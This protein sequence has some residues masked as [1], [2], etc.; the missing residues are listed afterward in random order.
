M[1]GPG[2][3]AAEGSLYAA[4]S[5]RH[6]QGPFDEVFIRSYQ[7]SADYLMTAWLH[8]PFA[9][10][11]NLIVQKGYEGI[12]GKRVYGGPS[13]YYAVDYT[14]NA[15]IVDADFETTWGLANIGPHINGVD[16]ADWAH[17]GAIAQSLLTGGQW[18]LNT[19]DAD[20]SQGGRVK[21]MFGYGQSGGATK[22]D[23]LPGNRWFNMINTDN[24]NKTYYLQCTD[25]DHAQFPAQCPVAGGP[26]TGY[27]Q[28]GVAMAATDASY[29]PYPKMRF[30]WE[31]PVAAGSDYFSPHYTSYMG[32]GMAAEMIMGYDVSHALADLDLRAPV[33]QF[34]TTTPQYNWDRNVVVPG[35]PAVVTYSD[36]FA[37]LSCG[38]PAGT[39]VA[40]L[41]LVKGNGNGPGAW[42]I[43]MASDPAHFAIS[44]N[45]LVT[46]GTIPCDKSYMV[47][48]QTTQSGG[49]SVLGE[50]HPHV[51]GAGG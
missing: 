10:Y 51:K 6:D 5:E 32:Q 11:L 46:A 37:T 2:S 15:D 8:E 24:V 25:A 28:A 45:N 18:V 31:P 44:G 9:D 49:R 41:G 35:L 29:L 27:T 42:T 16:G 50:L 23:Q 26:F 33:S 40:S 4:N 3:V 1:S 38:A 12:M 20:V 47:R 22:I 39:V 13:T 7:A 30:N 34:N 48:V 21:Y 36:Q 43:P 19:G 14:T 17:Y